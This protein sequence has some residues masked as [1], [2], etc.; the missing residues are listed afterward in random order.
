MNRLAFLPKPAS[1]LSLPLAGE[2]NIW[3]QL[4]SAATR[5]L[6]FTDALK[7]DRLI[8]KVAAAKP[9]GIE[10]V[11]SL[12]LA[13]LSSATTEHLIPGLRVAGARHNAMIHIYTHVYGSA[14]QELSDPESNLA[15]FHPDVVLTSYPYA[16]LFGAGQLAKTAEEV[17]EKLSIA[18]SVL[19]TVRDL[20]REKFNCSIIQQTILPVALPLVG[21]HEFQLSGAPATMAAELN[22]RL[23]QQ[24][25][26]EKF[27][28][29][30]IDSAAAI[31]GL[32]RWHDR[33]LWHHAKQE[34]SPGAG[35]A[36]GE[37]VLQVIDAQR[38]RTAKCLVL[39]L[40]NTLW[41][42]EIGE[43]G[44][45]GI[46]LGQGSAIG[47]S[48]A[49]FQGYVK[50]LSE[51][52]IILAV[53]SKNDEGNALLPFLK[54]PEMVIRREDVSCF[55][56]NWNDK[57]S[58]LR[59][60]ARRLNLGLDALVFCDDNPFE[61][62]QVRGALPQV[63]VPE[64]PDDATFFAETLAVAGYFESMSLTADDFSR[65]AQ[66]KL[67]AER[68]KLRSG[69]NNI[70]E[71][72]NNLEMELKW[73]ARDL[74]N[75]DRIT[76]LINK[77]NQFNLT[78]KRYDLAQVQ[79]MMARQ[80]TLVLSFRLVD[81]LGDNGIICVIIGHRSDQ[82]LLIDSWLMSC[83]VLGRGVEGAALTVLAAQ[84]DTLGAKRLVGRYVPSDRNKLVA[85]HF[86]KLGFS[87]AGTETD[88]VTIWSLDIAACVKP[89][90]IIKITKVDQ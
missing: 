58:N 60:I 54:H 32:S 13:I 23:R 81:R 21:N 10:S 80:E 16:H 51:R 65:V 4:I 70:D 25:I 50:Q 89:D 8:A 74:V 71:Y 75:S 6:S 20:A 15:A 69:S 37:M 33:A 1:R 5:Q 22:H 48:F 56:A 73:A 76:Q 66:Y 30:A 14:L 2:R 45:M 90:L 59:E 86:E 44:L 82:E 40:D 61:R 35:L 19:Q 12:K 53:C 85:D 49:A 72:L 64:M 63:R 83:R 88:G 18:T 17:E 78:T 31:D 36:Y 9:A 42:G 79:S 52:G 87:F 24:S 68:E 7:L 26:K 34:I 29:L 62:E 41:G 39:D 67:N 38:G 28:I 57:A 55:I 11:V 84:A 46:K 43:D 3:P 77:T 47:E 27:A